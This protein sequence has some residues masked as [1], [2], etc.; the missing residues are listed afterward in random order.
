MTKP[1]ESCSPDC[2]DRSWDCHIHCKIYAQQRVLSAQRYAEH[3]KGAHMR[4]T[5]AERYRRIQRRYKK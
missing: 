5:I 4:E 1:V 3:N 2:P